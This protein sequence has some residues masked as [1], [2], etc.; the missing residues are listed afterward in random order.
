MSRQIV[1]IKY[2]KDTNSTQFTYI[3]NGIPYKII[4]WGNNVTSPNELIKFAENYL[5]ERNIYVTGQAVQG[6]LQLN[7]K[8][9][10]GKKIKSRKSKSRKSKSRKS[11][12]RKSK[13]RK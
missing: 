2:Y 3:K 5:A 7:H 12:S 9:Y 1:D 8:P 13:S 11:K 10:G 4:I 6:L